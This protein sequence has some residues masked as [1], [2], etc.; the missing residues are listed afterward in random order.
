MGGASSAMALTGP[1]RDPLRKTPLSSSSILLALGC[2]DA[3]Q[4]DTVALSADKDGDGVAVC[5]LDD[6]AG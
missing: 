3:L 5:H 4:T 1:Q 6:F 2:V